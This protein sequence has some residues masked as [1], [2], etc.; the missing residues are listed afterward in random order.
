MSQTGKP[1]YLLVRDG[2][3]H[4]GSEGPPDGFFVRGRVLEHGF[5]PEGNLQGNGELGESGHPGWMELFDGSFHG[6]E[7][8]RLPARPY[9]KGFMS[10]E[11][12][13]KPSSREVVY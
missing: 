6:D 10:P 13:F 12:E 5:A 11:G 4:T 2:T 1:G 3:I 8:S 9:I 7:T